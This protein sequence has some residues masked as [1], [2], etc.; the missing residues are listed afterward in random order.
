VD[1][2]GGGFKTVEEHI[3]FVLTELFR[4][5]EPKQFFTLKKRSRSIHP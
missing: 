5:K 4:E 3:E 1:G 2:S